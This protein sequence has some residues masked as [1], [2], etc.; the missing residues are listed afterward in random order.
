MDSSKTEPAIR[1]GSSDL[2]RSRGFGWVLG[3]IFAIT[4]LRQR[5]RRS[6]QPIQRPVDSSAD[7]GTIVRN[8]YTNFGQL[9]R[10]SCRGE[11][12]PQCSPGPLRFNPSETT[13]LPFARPAST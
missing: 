3:T 12:S 8:M 2:E 10:V 7:L 11:R 13:T 1:C 6:S 4:S 9:F 5:D